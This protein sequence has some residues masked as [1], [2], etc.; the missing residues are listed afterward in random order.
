MSDPP[1]TKRSSIPGWQQKELS[2][3]DTTPDQDSPAPEHPEH[4]DAP[5]PRAA[6]F[7][8]ASKF[9]EE[10]HIKDAP[11]EKK[12]AFLKTKGLRE[13]EI[14]T[15]LTT[16]SDEQ[17]IQ[18]PKEE[19][20]IEQPSTVS[21][22]HLSKP[23]IPAQ[24]PPAEKDALPPIITYPEFLLHS[25]KPPPL[26]TTS[27]LLNTIY[28]FSTF[29]AAV[30]GTSKYL[31]APMLESLASARHSLFVNA[32]DNLSTLNEKLEKNI[33][34]VPS[35]NSNNNSHEDDTD[36]ESTTSTES[37][38]P[39]FNRT[40]GTQTS[41]PASPSSPSSP[42]AVIGKTDKTAIQLSALQSLHSTLSSL[43]PP[44]ASAS[45]K[46]DNDDPTAQLTDLKSYLNTLK[47]ANVYSHLHTES[48]NDA[49]SAF[50]AEIR[51][52]KGVLLS[53]RT[54][55]AARGMRSSGD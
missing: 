25:Q 44:R 49:V 45:T 12:I 21:S 43:I 36:N 53:A 38:S 55:P 11:I 33:S 51:G 6:L 15:L 17:N 48:K 30:Y 14:N 8:Q 9:L 31:V 37:L 4:I 34:M 10:E 47:Y 24:Q 39:L 28:A 35:G 20:V 41:T 52:V 7:E 3:P 40:I 16:P 46:N 50:K 29:S 42:T 2:E 26:I 18:S 1:D 23:E 19:T 32:Q 27:N 13:G 5:P 22:N 54:F